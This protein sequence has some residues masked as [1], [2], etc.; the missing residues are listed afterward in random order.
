MAWYYVLL[1]SWLC[2][3]LGYHYGNHTGTKAA[4]AAA[5]GLLRRAKNLA[6]S[7][8]YNSGNL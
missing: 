3:V 2:Y 5:A 7:S 1:L 8:R 6:V 4:T